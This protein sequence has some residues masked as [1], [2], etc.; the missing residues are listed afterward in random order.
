MSITESV[1]LSFVRDCIMLDLCVSV[2]PLNHQFLAD[3]E[4]VFPLLCSYHLALWLAQSLYK[5]IYSIS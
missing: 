4:L 2:S 3:S 1:H 5:N